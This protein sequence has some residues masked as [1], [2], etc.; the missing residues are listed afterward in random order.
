MEKRECTN[1]KRHLK[2]RAQRRF[3]S[4]KCQAEHQYASFVAAWKSGVKDG[5]IGVS[6][7]ATSAHLKRY[8]LD[9]YNNKCPECG[10]DRKNVSTNKVPLEID[11]IDG[12]SE[13]NSEENLRLL[14]PNCHSLTANYKNLN[15]GKGRK[16]RM[17]KYIKTV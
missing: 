10:W 9:K 17:E 8:L 4:N 5:G 12:N 13:N 6:V 11:H 16:W 1:C 3:C 2:N 14:C 15:R 7:H